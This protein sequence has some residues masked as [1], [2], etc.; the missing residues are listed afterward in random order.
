[1]SH[2]YLDPDEPGLDDRTR[3]RRR[4]LAEMREMS[5]AE[6]LAFAVQV[7]ISTPDGQLTSNY[8]HDAEPSACRPTD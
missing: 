7:G 1:M 6:F 4:I 3:R 2:K 5:T 8:R